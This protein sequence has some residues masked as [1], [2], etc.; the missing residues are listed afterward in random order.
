MNSF[1]VVVCFGLVIAMTFG[2]RAGL[3]R[4]AVTI[5]G[6]V[7]AM[8]IALWITA[9]IA[10]RLGGAS[11]LPTAQTSM[12]FVAAFLVSG[13]GLGALLRTAIDEM[14]G[15]H[16]GLTD[17]LGGAALGAARVGLIAITMVLIFDELIPANA[18]PTFLAGSQLRPL[19][20]AAGQQGF[21]SLPPDVAAYIAQLKQSH[22]L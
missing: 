19:L 2:F 5:L 3:L 6:Y 10:P 16:I 12:A 15:A 7:V 20:S 11:D 21:K 14:A 17:R 9:L 13:I 22:R 4:S 1:D 18:Q 8:P